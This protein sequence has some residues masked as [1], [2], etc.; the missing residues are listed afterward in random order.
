MTASMRTTF[1]AST[2]TDIAGEVLEAGLF[3]LQSVVSRDQVDKLI[4]PVGVGAGGAVFG[5]S[6]IRQRNCRPGDGPRAGIRDG[7]DDGTI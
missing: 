5:R 7:P 1:C 4:I 3:D 2:A 6:Q